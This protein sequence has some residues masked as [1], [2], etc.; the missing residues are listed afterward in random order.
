MVV[1]EPWLPVM[2]SSSRLVVVGTSDGRSNALWSKRQGRGG[3]TAT[4]CQDQAGAS[5]WRSSHDLWHSPPETPRGAPCLRQSTSSPTP[6][7]SPD[8]TAGPWQAS[9]GGGRCRGRAAI[10]QGSMRGLDCSGSR[11]GT[12]T[13]NNM[14]SRASS[15]AR[16]QRRPERGSLA[17]STQGVWLVESQGWNL[18]A[19]AAAR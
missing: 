4:D 13:V 12:R 19:S 8:D 16:G 7:W 3:R 2:L 5:G 9:A 1:V 14:T 15:A 6:D 10:R 18:A 11:D 17:V